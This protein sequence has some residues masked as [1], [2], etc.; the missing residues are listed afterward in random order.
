MKAPALRRRSVLAGLAGTAAAGVT[1]CPSSR[2]QAAP[3][4]RFVGQSP[5]RGH[6]IRDRSIA[7]QA[8]ARNDRVGVLI[9]GGGVAGVSA[10]W[11][12]HRAGIEDV[13][14]LELESDLGGTAAGGEVPRT[15]Y[16]MG[17]HYLPAPHPEYTALHTVLEEV[18]VILGRD[19]DGS[20]TYDPS[21]I[22]ASPLER[23]R[24]RG[25]WFEGIYPALGQTA[26]ESAQ[27][28][29][30]LDHLRELDSRV[31]PDGRRLFALPLEASSSALRHLDR[32]SM[33]AYLDERGLSSWRLRWTIDYACRDDYGCALGQTSAFAGL[34][35]FLCRGLEER[36]D[37]PILAW[38]GGNGDLVAAM[39][40]QCQLDER[41]ATDTAALRVDAQTGVVIAYDFAAK[42]VVRIEAEH[43]L[44][45][46]PRFVLRHCVERDPLPNDALSYA[47]WL[48]ANV[49]VGARPA[50]IG[51]AL[52]WDN[53]PVEA[54]HLGYVVATHG[55]SLVERNQANTVLSFYQPLIA[56]DAAGLAAARQQ[57]LT[58]DLPGWTE[59]VI[60]RLD[61]MHPGL[62]ETA[63]SLDIARW[64]HAMIRPVPTL[65]FGE[66]LKAA[67]APIGRVHPCGADV[68]G[69]PLFEQAFA[70]G[71]MTAERVMALRGASIESLLPSIGPEGGGLG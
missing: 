10:A 54:D 27:W 41:R 30:W 47:P 4:A 11:R 59:H 29:R 69:L 38:P 8:A 45:A 32:M 9:V 6:V 25:R 17:A 5:E 62:R 3:V 60:G 71:V 53:V 35:H 22:C 55:E 37:R 56:D 58:R 64:G 26:D 39:A 65:A 34:H 51:A 28:E 2:T 12:L 61:Q 16:P 1:G 50:G 49:S 66:S 63:Q 46:A 33:A 48:V 31:G 57:M 14:L 21:R 7:S 36:H 18:G 68:G 20:A 19:A 13:R 70:N 43:I 67:R 24:Y 44:W 52:A 42:E 15:R 40:R 23:H